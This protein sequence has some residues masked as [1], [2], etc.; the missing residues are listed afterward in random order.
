MKEIPFYKPY[1]DKKEKQYVNEVL[2][3]D[4]PN[5][6]KTLEDSFSKYINTKY[7]IS[8]NNGT[9]AMHLAMCALDLKRGDKIL[10]SVNSFPSVAE[11]IRHF[12]AEPI[13]ID[14]DEDDFNINLDELEILLEKNRSK[15]LKGVYLNHI[16]GQPTDLERLY[17]IAKLYDIKVIEDASEAMGATYNGARIGG[18]KADITTFRFSPQMKHAVASGG[19]MTTNDEALR[20]RAK[21]LRN[22]AI[23]NERWDAY[24]NLGYVYDVVDIGLKYDMNE[25]NAAYALG[26]LEKNRDFIK[27][28]QLIAKIYDEELKD[29]PHVRTPVEKREHIFSQYIIKVDKNRDSFARELKENGINT[30]LH[31]IP[32]HLLTYYKHKYNIRVNDFPHALN[33]YQKILSL[34]IYHS[35]KN[36]DV[37]YIC[38]QIKKI[39]KTRV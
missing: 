28:R 34:P 1:I 6:V 39:A 2:E 5:K 15:K 26:Q 29:C 13:F 33:N 7:A 23:V 17:K 4:S 21:L 38:E 12:D 19:I 16:A 9:S 31:Y 18:L 14:I 24:G 10:C 11:V 36:K 3:L 32:I 35:L 27:R 22:H 25:L 20:D 30:A 8:T 37:Y